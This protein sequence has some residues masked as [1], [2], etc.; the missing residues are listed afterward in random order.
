M[1]SIKPTAIKKDPDAP[2]ASPLTVD[3]ALITPIKEENLPT[4]TNTG[5]ADTSLTTEGMEPLTVKQSAYID[6]VMT[7]ARLEADAE[8]DR[9][10]YE[11]EF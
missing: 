1:Q 7:Q 11:R 8:K 5:S 2:R 4:N 3:D 10:Y 9:E 6:A